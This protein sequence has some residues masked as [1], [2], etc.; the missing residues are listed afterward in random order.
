MKETDTE[1]RHR[2]YWPAALN[3]K[4]AA[5]YCGISY[6][7]FRQLCPV[8][9][10]SVTDLAWGQR[11]LR[12]RLD[13]WL[14]SQDPNEAIGAH[15]PDASDALESWDSWEPGPRKSAEPR[16]GAGGYP[17]VDDPK[18]PL[19]EWY[20]RLGFDPETMSEEDMSRLIA[21]AHE[22]CAA[23]IPGTKLGKRRDQSL[24]SP[25]G[26]RP[27]GESSLARRQGLRAGYRGETQDQRFH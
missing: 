7:L 26:D 24:E 16:K 4:M 10:I 12:Q 18:H 6:E 19:K 21:K 17:I 14:L 1:G 5:A 20:N 23:A 3:K 9:P 11:Y 2:P 25:R 8:K 13:E 22:E 27:E 15:P